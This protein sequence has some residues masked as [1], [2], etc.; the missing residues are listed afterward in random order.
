V[1][2]TLKRLFD[3]G[4][5]ST[6]TDLEVRSVTEV[7][8]RELE[9]GRQEV[10][11]V[12]RRALREVVAR[13]LKLSQKDAAVA[14]D[15]YCEE[16]APY[17]P[18]YLGNE[19]LLPYIKLSGLVIAVFSLGLIGY[20]VHRWDERALSWPFFL[21]GAFFF[22]LSGIGLLKALRYEAGPTK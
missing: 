4:E 20:G 12:S 2:Y 1:R 3:E 10:R 13:E 21:A 9:R 6:T 8:E 5:M 18:D 14:V 22:T 16:V 11:P 7:I 19:F 17:T 15:N